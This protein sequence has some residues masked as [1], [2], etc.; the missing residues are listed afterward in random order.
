MKITVRDVL[1]RWRVL[2]VLAAFLVAGGIKAFSLTNNAGY[3]PTQPI[4]FSHKL[5]AGQ[6]GL[7]CLYCHGQ[8]ER[9]KHATVPGMDTCMGCHS[10]VRTDRPAIQDLTR[11]WENEEPVPWV[12]IHSLPDHA[13]F[14]HKAHVA[15]G[16]DCQTCHGPVETMDIVYQYVDMSMGWCMN[17]HRNDDYLRTPATEAD[18]VGL[19]GE[20][21]DEF[22]S[23]KPYWDAR[24]LQT[25][26]AEST[27]EELHKIVTAALGYDSLAPQA[28]KGVVDHVRAFQNA[29]INCNT[30]HQ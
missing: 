4:P 21:K 27:P 11:Y 5:H 25:I 10:V 8:A 14:S 26:A 16:V 24:E 1:A 20:A 30:C 19:T 17:C 6:L 7:D 18:F 2:F 29:S 9:S 13:F 22:R 12:R 15:A 23:L 28:G 3:A